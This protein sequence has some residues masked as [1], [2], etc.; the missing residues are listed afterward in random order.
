MSLFMPFSHRLRLLLLVLVLGSSLKI[1][2]AAAQTPS[3][4]SPSQQT[5]NI[6]GDRQVSIR[7]LPGNIIEDQKRIWNFP[8]KPERVH[9]WWPPAI[10]LGV[11][12]AVVASDPYTA[13][14]FLNTT[15]FHGYNQVFSGTN[16]EA[17]IA[18]IPAAIYGVGW[19]RKD[20][21]AQNSALLSA[22][23]AADVYLLNMPIKFASARRQP[24]SYSGPGPYVDNFFDG[25]H[26]PFHSGGFFSGH[27][28][29]SMAVATVIAHRYRR[30]RWVPFVA[31][32]LAGAISFSR[33]TTSNHFPGDAVFGSAMGFLVAH[34]VVLPA[35]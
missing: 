31:Y 23:A 18:G 1:Q 16:T 6:S 14:H 26:S 24:L 4:T 28:S 8:F 7:E 17:L 12:G 34:Y 22:E 32:G 35:H 21:Y 15:N 11:T 9:H 19:L 10:V 30:H 33:V 20:S 13:P 3:P 5:S 25:S 27:A 2:P 29:L